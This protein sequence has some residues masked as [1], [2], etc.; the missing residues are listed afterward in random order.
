M[1]ALT[2]FMQKLSVRSKLF[3][4]SSATLL[5]LLVTC[6]HSY[7]VVKNQFTHVAARFKM[8]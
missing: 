1:T 2:I 6:W 4:R 8:A 7:K 3:R 5:T